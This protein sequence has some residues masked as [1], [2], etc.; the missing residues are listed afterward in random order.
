MFIENYVIGGT[1]LCKTGLHI[2]GSSD[3][4]DI[5]GLIIL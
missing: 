5:G 3:N 2:G 4:I 1:I